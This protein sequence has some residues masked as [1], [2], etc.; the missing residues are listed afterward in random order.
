MLLF[1]VLRAGSR[2]AHIWQVLLTEG[3]LNRSTIFAL[4]LMDMVPSS[5][6]YRY[7]EHTAF[8]TIKGENCH[9]QPC[10]NRMGFRNVSRGPEI[11]C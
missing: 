3:L 2:V 7:L 5:L 6:T 8:T 10:N 4:F 1:P 9:H 11:F